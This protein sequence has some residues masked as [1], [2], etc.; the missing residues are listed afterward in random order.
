[1]QVDADLPL[2]FH[3]SLCEHLFPCTVVPLEWA[4]AEAISHTY[5]SYWGHRRPEAASP[6][7]ASALR[8]S[9]TFSTGLDGSPQGAASLPPPG[10]HDSLLA[11]LESKLEA[12]IRRRGGRSFLKVAGQSPKDVALF[13]SNTVMKS[14]LQQALRR[15]ESSDSNAQ[16]TAFLASLNAALCVTSGAQAI[17][18]ITRS[19]RIAAALRKKLRRCLSYHFGQPGASPSREAGGSAPVG[20]W[21]EGDFHQP[22]EA[23]LQI[24]VRDFQSLR[25]EEEFRCFVY[26]RQ[27]TAISQYECGLYSPSLQGE[28]GTAMQVRLISFME[29]IL[30][31]LRGNHF[32]VDVVA[33]PPP[34]DT[35]YIVEVHLWSEEISGCLFDWERDRALLLGQRAGSP[36]FRCRPAPLDDPLVAIPSRKWRA[37]MKDFYQQEAQRRGA[38]TLRH[39]GGHL[40]RYLLHY[41]RFSRYFSIPFSAMVVLWFF[42]SKPSSR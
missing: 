8:H 16:L 41:F 10:P 36:H 7:S 42:R 1:M 38:L 9:G 31:L 2:A 28:E 18:Y 20:G 12:A 37:F 29:S 11:T 21:M 15:T 19:H 26:G 25:V 3:K 4:E 40:I 34:Q 32:V 30:P 24:V 6:S 35:F 14:S 27:L 33:A 5:D 23:P 22:G 13:Q 39:R 17:E